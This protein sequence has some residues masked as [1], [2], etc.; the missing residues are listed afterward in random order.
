MGKL[1]NLE[2]ITDSDRAKELQKKSV[3][4]RLEN[5]VKNKLI[6]EAIR[7][8]L[9]DDD[10]QEIARNL[11]TRSKRNS[12]DLTIMRDTIGEKPTDKVEA[13]VTANIEIDI[14]DE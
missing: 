2:I 3:E 11:I 12:N 7:K 4:K 13:N 14:E 10:L 5:K 6:E 8:Q 9:T 1:E